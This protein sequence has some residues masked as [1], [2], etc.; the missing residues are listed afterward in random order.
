LKIALKISESSKVF[1]VEEINSKMKMVLKT[2]RMVGGNI[3]KIKK[4][5]VAQI[6]MSS[7]CKFL[8]QL[9]DFFIID[10]NVCIIMEYCSRGSLKKKLIERTRIV[11]PVLFYFYF[12]FL[13][14]I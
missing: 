4:T 3:D 8:V 7:R 12:F 5:L 14:N 9:K 11:Q 13:I 10:E 2:V 1:V 6:E